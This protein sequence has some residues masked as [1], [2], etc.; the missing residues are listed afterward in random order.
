MSAK[1]RAE[2]SMKEGD[3]AKKD[4]S[5]NEKTEEEKKA[6]E[7]KE[8]KKDADAGGFVPPELAGLTGA[9]KFEP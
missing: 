2:A 9:N 1:Q 4:N 8:E 5:G 6:A 3:E 7:K